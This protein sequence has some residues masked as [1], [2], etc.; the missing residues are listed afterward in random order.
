MHY[1]ESY[2]AG[3]IH[4]HK[5]KLEREFLGPGSGDPGRAHILQGVRTHFKPPNPPT[6]GDLDEP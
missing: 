1:Q 2:L 5:K 3:S 6:E 4:T